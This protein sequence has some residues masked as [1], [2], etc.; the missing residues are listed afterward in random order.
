MRPVSRFTTGPFRLAVSDLM[1]QP[2]LS[3]IFIMYGTR[4]C[5]LIPLSLFA[6]AMPKTDSHDSQSTSPRI[7]SR[8]RIVAVP[9]YSV[10]PRLAEL[11]KKKKNMIT[12]ACLLRKATS[13]FGDRGIIFRLLQLQTRTGKKG[14]IINQLPSMPCGLGS[15]YLSQ[16]SSIFSA[17]CKSLR[18]L[19]SSRPGLLLP[20]RLG[21][22]LQIPT[23]PIRRQC[24]VIR[25]VIRSIEAIRC[26]VL[27]LRGRLNSRFVIVIRKRQ[28]ND[29]GN[30]TLATDGGC[31]SRS[32]RGPVPT[33][34]DRRADTRGSGLGS[35]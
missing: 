1:Q 12:D 9:I 21:V 31:S 18:S 10:T 8:R 27:T 2:R 34:C 3:S 19:T 23:R 17:A 22:F 26:R 24:Q 6:V 7:W 13:S 29:S 15:N 4:S 25:Q 28:V 32:R 14:N 35:L 16:A 33:G 20:W 11:K 5:Y 30:W